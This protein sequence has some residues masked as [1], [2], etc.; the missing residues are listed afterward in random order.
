MSC[1]RYIG[2]IIFLMISFSSVRIFGQDKRVNI[3]SLKTILQNTTSDT[4][5][6]NILLALAA[7]N[8]N[9]TAENLKYSIEAKSLAEK[10]NWMPGLFKAN[11]LIGGIYFFQKDYVTASGFFPVFSDNSSCG[12]L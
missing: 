7:A 6:I 11:D 1:L 9:H 12:V 3:D 4:N 8:P 5:R 2:F 10:A